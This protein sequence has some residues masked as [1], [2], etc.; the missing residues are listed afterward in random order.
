MCIRDSRTNMVYS[1]SFVT[2]GRGKFLVTAIG[3][4]TEV[5]KIAQLLKSTEEK[6]TPLQVNLDNFGKKLSII[7]IVF[8]AILFG[9]SL[10]HI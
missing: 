6:K 9:L 3:M 5:G 4:E 7:I 1:G 2:Y 8:C 10:I